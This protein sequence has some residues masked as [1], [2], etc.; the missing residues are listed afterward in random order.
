MAFYEDHFEIVATKGNTE[1]AL[2]LKT[3]KGIEL[4]FQSIEKNYITASL[5]GFVYGIACL[6]GTIERNSDCVFRL[7]PSH[8]KIVV[9]CSKRNDIR[10]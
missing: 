1:W 5:N 7:K 2:E 4:P 9:D 6:E 10:L 8:N 3:A